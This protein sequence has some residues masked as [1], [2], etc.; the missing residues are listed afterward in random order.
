MP[1]SPVETY[2]I[3]AHPLYSNTPH[4]QTPNGKDIRIIITEP[5]PTERN[6]PSRA[7]TR[8]ETPKRMPTNNTV[9]IPS[10]G[11]NNISRGFPTDFNNTSV[12]NGT[13]TEKSFS[14]NS[15]RYIK[16]KHV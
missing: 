13:F 1:K 8:I 12:G 15:D 7:L 10:S 3:S 5:S 11:K 2:T 6:T 4:L 9:E 14:T 16:V